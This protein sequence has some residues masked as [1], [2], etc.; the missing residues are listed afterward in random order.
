MGARISIQFANGNRK[1]PVLFSHWG[2]ESIIDK[3]NEYLEELKAEQTDNGISY[4]LDRLEPSTVMV[5]FIRDLT[6]DMS[7]VSSDYYLGIDENDG[8]NSDYGHHVIS[9]KDKEELNFDSI[10]NNYVNGNLREF[11]KQLNKLNAYDMARFLDH[12]KYYYSD[13]TAEEV[14]RQLKL[15]Q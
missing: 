3:V 10:A 14:T 7:R 1:S 2:G 8:D 11:R 6:K 12:C 15:I 4:P 5:D 13:L 9:L